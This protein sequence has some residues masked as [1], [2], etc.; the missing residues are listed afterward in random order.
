MTALPPPPLKL[1]RLQ[2]RLGL[3]LMDYAAVR[4]YP[5]DMSGWVRPGIGRL[6]ERLMYDILGLRFEI[7]DVFLELTNTAP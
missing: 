3:Q 4:P 5:L 7:E 6:V 1:S 2:R